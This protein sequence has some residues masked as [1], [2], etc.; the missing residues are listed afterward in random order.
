MPLNE[1]LD[2]ILAIVFD[3]WLKLSKMYATVQIF[4]IK[5]VTGKINF[6]RYKR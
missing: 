5:Y 6:Y 1:Q 4:D 2:L 3:H